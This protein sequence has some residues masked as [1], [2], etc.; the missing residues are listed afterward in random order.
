MVVDVVDIRKRIQKVRNDVS[1]SVLSRRLPNATSEQVNQD[2]SLE[3]VPAE[4]EDTAQASRF[5]Q[6]SLPLEDTAS[7]QNI[8]A[9]TKIAHRAVTD[10]MAMPSF[11][12]NITNR[13]SSRLLMALIALQ[14]FT[15]LVLVI[16]LI[17][18]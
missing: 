16:V 2:V 17:L 14:L 7:A 3:F 15:N 8:P 6:A 13:H 10:A 9:S 18:K 1:D 5:S 4:H 11:N 12:L